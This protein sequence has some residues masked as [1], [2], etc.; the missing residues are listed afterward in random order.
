MSENKS[1]PMSEYEWDEICKKKVPTTDAGKAEYQ[2]DRLNRWRAERKASHRE[3]VLIDAIWYMLIAVGF[4]VLSIWLKGN[5]QTTAII[6]GAVMGMIS[7][8][9]FG[10]A[11]ALRR[12]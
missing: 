2:K 1:V 5:W 10:M 3:K 11:R 7:T 12:K 6:L 9:G 8:Y 4:G